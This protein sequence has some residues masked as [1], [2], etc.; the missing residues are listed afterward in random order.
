MLQVLAAQALRTLIIHPKVDE[1]H[2]IL[3]WE[4]EQLDWAALEMV[5]RRAEIVARAGTPRDFPYTTTSTRRIA[6]SPLALSRI[7]S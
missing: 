3:D 7:R 6:D 2:S 1:E 4:T 5:D